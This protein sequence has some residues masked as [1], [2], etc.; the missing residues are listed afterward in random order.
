L[1][2]WQLRFLLF[3][4]FNLI[5]FQLSTG[6]LYVVDILCSKG[7]F[8]DSD[9][10]NFVKFACHVLVLGSIDY[11]YCPNRLKNVAGFKSGQKRSKVNQKQSSSFTNQNF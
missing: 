1:G 8:T 9:K 5:S 10:L 2:T 3:G 4:C 11:N 6:L 7:R